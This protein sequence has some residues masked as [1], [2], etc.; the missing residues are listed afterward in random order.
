M[1]KKMKKIILLFFCTTLAIAADYNEIPLLKWAGPPGSEPETYEEWITAHPMREPSYIRDR[2]VYGDGRAGTVALLTEQNIAQ[3]IAEEI[4]QLTNNLTSE[5]YTVLSYQIDGGSPEDLRNFLQGLYASDSIE[6][7]FF[8]G[9]IPVAWFEIADDFNQYGYT[10]FPCELFFMDLDGT[11][12]DT[13]NTGNGKYD[14]HQGELSPE[15][16]IGRLYP[17]NL[18]D[19]TLLLQNYFK[20]DNAFRHDTLLLTQRA[21]VFVDDDWIPWANQWADDVALL[22]PDTMNYWDAETTR[23]SVYR[24]KLDTTQAWVSVFAHSWPGGHQF[25]YN[26]GSSHDYYYASEY[27]AQNP[28]TNFYNF[29]ACSFS[30]YTESSNCG[31]S[32]AIFN[33]D[34]GLCSIGSTK[35]GSML[36]FEYFYNWLGSGTN[37][38]KAF[39]EWF[40]HIV[41]D[42]VTFEELCWH[43]GMTLL[44]DCFLIPKGHNTAVKE[45]KSEN[46]AS[47][48]F[49]LLKNP[50]SDLI[51]LNLRIDNITEVKIT[52][53]DCTGRAHIFSTYTLHAGENR[54]SIKESGKLPAG[55]YFLKVDIGNRTATR[56]IVKL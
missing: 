39:K 2:V 3:S 44:G 42:G 19:D 25:A 41:Q 14:G 15:I 50:I 7:A 52:V 56:K 8:I 40:T 46:P 38:G 34:Y 17:A 51:Q 5:G 48:P 33:Q 18:G 12:L 32:R 22:Y 9:D 31:G 37:L 16:Y 43:Y 13:M 36:D 45:S 53:F 20:K 21:L 11:W 35:T 23:A 54:I 29:F 55:I 1:K 6:G 27:T 4:T 49:T 47:A 28:L 30:R 10:D 26:S 24:T